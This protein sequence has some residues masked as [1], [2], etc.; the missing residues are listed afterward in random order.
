[1]AGLAGL[2]A[3]RR[4]LLAGLGGGA[5][6]RR[7]GRQC[8][9]RPRLSGPA[10]AHPAAVCRRHH[11]LSRSAAAGR[12]PFPGPVGGACAR[13]RAL[14]AGLGRQC[15]DGGF[16]QRRWPPPRRP[17]R[18]QPGAH[19]FGPGRALP[20]PGLCRRRGL[21][22]RHRHR[23][24]PGR[25]Q[26][27]CRRRPG[28]TQPPARHRPAWR[29]AAGAGQRRR[30]R[31]T[32]FLPGTG[33]RTGAGPGAGRHGRVCTRDGGRSGMILRGLVVLLACMNLGVALWWW[34]HAPPSPP[35]APPLPSGVA[36][37]VL[38]GE[39]EAP[40]SSDLVELASVPVPLPATPACLSIGPFETPAQ[41]RTA[42]SALTPL[43]A[44]I[45]Y[46]E[47]QATSLRGYRVFLPAAATREQ[48]LASARELAA[49]GVRDY[50]VVTAG[51]QENTV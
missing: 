43:V 17:D 28:R 27:G 35:A 14:V 8:P 3:T 26:P 39:V 18:A 47:L 19:A 21:R 38:L 36:S 20:G 13:A 45:Q 22:F 33:Q 24:R 49:R 4:P 1:P 25:R 32:A 29:G 6:A 44:R 51:E 50:Y 5:G 15:P 10:G 7:P 41:L 37:L 30:R 11:C 9:G 46:R 34:L 16:A 42:M 48:A 2:A 12:R 31:T 23:R 40:P